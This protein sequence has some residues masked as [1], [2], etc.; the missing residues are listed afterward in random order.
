M[1]TYASISPDGPFELTW[2]NLIIPDQLENIGM[3]FGHVA[4]DIPM[5]PIP[6]SR[7]C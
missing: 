2:M 6:M 5:F 1:Y 3:K 7:L 4:S